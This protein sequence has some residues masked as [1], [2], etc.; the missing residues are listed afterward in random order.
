M[1]K[2]LLSIALFLLPITVISFVL[3][4]ETNFSLE[5]KEVNVFY[6]KET[7]KIEVKKVV[8]TDT[9]NAEEETIRVLINGKVETIPL[10]TYVIGVVAAEMPASFNVEALKAQAVASRSF[11]LYRKQRATG[12]Y[13]VTDDTR[14]QVYISTDTMKK[15]W[16]NSFDKY[17]NRISNAVLAT[18]GEVA[19]YNGKIIEALYS[20][21][22]GGI[23]QNVSSVWGGSRDY[24]VSVESKYD[25]ETIKDFKSTRTIDYNTF[26]SKLSLS[27]DKIIIDYIKKNE[28]D[29]ISSISVCGKVF[30]GS[31]FIWKLSLKSGDADIEVADNIIIT[32]YGF[33]HGVGMSQYGAN[34]Y[35]EHGYTYEE[36]LKHYYTNI[37]ISDLKVV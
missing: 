34:G 30:S 6:N 9:I 33:G 8:R 17:Y 22:S 27:C 2:K 31:D 32:T 36:I 7:P 13:D 20:A 18:K 19:T 29:Y 35:A 21:M 16:G 24:L 1:N 37:E 12:N 11:A 10:E 26:K 5:K 28:S 3:K 15:R 4:S 23:T 14:T 25:N